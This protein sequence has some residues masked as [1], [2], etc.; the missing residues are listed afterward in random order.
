MQLLCVIL[1]P[2]YTVGE[3]VLLTLTCII[4]AST[5]WMCFQTLRDFVARR[6]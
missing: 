4:A 3:Y 2:V 5:Y 6:M 1:G